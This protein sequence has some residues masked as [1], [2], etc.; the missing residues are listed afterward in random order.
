MNTKWILA[1]ITLAIVALGSYKA[2]Q[3]SVAHSS[4]SEEIKNQIRDD[5]VTLTQKDFEEYQNLK[6]LEERYQKAD[7]ILGKIV[8]VFLAD[9]GVKLA[10]KSTSPALLDAS[11][12][13]PAA[14]T[15]VATTPPAPATPP[16]SQGTPT[17]TAAPATVPA[18][19]EWKG[20]EKA[21]LEVRDEHQA[22]ED[23]KK[24]EIKD[25]FS[26]LRESTA[27]STKNSEF[28]LGLYA[29]EITFFDR[30]KHKSDWLI[31]WDVRLRNPNKEDAFALVILTRKDTGK[32]IS[33]SQTSSGP[34][35][36][37][38]TVPGSKALI[39]NIRAD[40]AY[41]QIYPLNGNNQIWVGNVYEQV[42]LGEYAMVGQVRLTKQ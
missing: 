31:S 13:I 5:L 35:R 11:C 27:V 4:N 34:L 7:E 37:Y 32:V 15:S 41:I 10:F 12:A 8:T 6:S 33:R 39:V 38:V 30:K 18:G 24:M 42:K 17:P 40:A 36:D 19:N 14:A 1:V 29:G 28:I 22:F 20:M 25:L 3:S 21:L 2:G 16:L 9:L 23:L 26:S